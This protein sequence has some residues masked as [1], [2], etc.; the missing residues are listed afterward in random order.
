LKDQRVEGIKIK[1]KI[2][3]GEKISGWNGKGDSQA[4][5]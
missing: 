3:E 4:I 5:K 1:E 2:M